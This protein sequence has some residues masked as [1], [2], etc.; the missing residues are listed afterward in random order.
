[1]RQLI[2]EN[3]HTNMLP[4]PFELS[5]RDQG[6]NNLVVR[7]EEDSTCPDLALSGRSNLV[8]QPLPITHNSNNLEVI[9]VN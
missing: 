9:Q 1:M 4:R 5:Q 6:N 3:I 8:M 2:D 7:T